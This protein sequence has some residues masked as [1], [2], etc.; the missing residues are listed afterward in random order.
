MKDGASAANGSYDFEFLLYDSISGGV[1]IGSVISRNAVAVANG[2]FSVTL[3]FGS[4]FPGADRFLEIRV[5]NAGV[6]G[7]TIL[8]PRQKVSS[9]PYSVK[10]L[11]S[12]NAAF[13]N[14]ATT[15]GNALQLGGVAA[16]QFV[17][18]TDP[19]MTNERPPTAGSGNY[20]QNNVL[21]QGFANFGIVG[22]G[23]VAG[24]LTGNTVNAVN[25]YNLN[26]SRILSNA[27]TNNLF[28]G[29]LVGQLNTGSFNSFFGRSAGQNNG[30]GGGNS[31]FGE[32]SGLSNTTGNSNS[33]FGRESGE[34][35]T[36]GGDNSFFGVASGA[37]NTTG[38]SNS[39][40]GRNAGLDNTTGSEN[41]F[42]GREAGASNTEG[43][44]NAFFGRSAGTANTTGAFNSLFGYRAGTSNTTGSSNSFFGL[45]AGLDTTS[46]GSNAFVGRSAGENNTTGGFNS[47]FG[48]RAGD[49][50][51]TGSNNTM[52]GN[53]ANPAAS[54][55]TFATAIGAGTIAVASNAINIGRTSDTVIT[56]HLL[57]IGTFEPGGTTN[58]CRNI[59]TIATCSSSLRYKTNINGFGLGINLIN[60]LK[61]ITFNWKNGGMH[62]LGLGAEDVAAIEPLLVTYNANG[63]VEG[64]KYDRLS[65]A[66]VNAFKEQQ[67][68]IEALEQQIKEQKAEIDAFKEL[69][70]S[71]NPTARICLPKN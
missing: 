44:Q 57:E 35:N 11:N 8:D 47:F 13:A 50:N 58:V 22:N 7:H 34:S 20:I 19:R 41:S 60:Q 18:T 51:I 30:S 54:N 52:I 67:V 1:Q 3:D 2:V 71:Q 66:F 39:F 23:T 43:L 16:N 14:I 40:F 64:V 29:N 56:G 5:R 10:S 27:G 70:C 25:Q 36:T 32:S 4:G 65:L 31:F 59:N 53:D 15:A 6:G 42:F 48:R 68:Q 69:V 33:F 46:G 12:E 63:E 9:S 61:P 17:L 24:T 55:L 37:G 26:N 38:T 49:A 28:V 21:G 45:N 62:D